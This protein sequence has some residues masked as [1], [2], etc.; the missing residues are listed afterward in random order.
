M[1]RKNDIL[2]KT[3]LEEVFGDLLRFVFKDA[4]QI[5]DMDRGFEFLDKELAEIYPEPEKDSH[6]RFVDKLVKVFRKDGREEWLLVHVEV[7]GETEAKD[8]A[9]FAVRMLEY[10]TRI[11]FKHRKPVAAIAIF[12]GPDG[13]QMPD[14][15]NYEFKNTR[16]EFQYHTLCILDYDDET[17]ASS[18]NPFA[19]V[20]LAA[21]K[22]MVSGKDV[23]AKLLE[24]KLFVFRKLY[25]R[26]IFGKPNMEAILEFLNNYV[27]FE[28]SKTNRIFTEEIDKITGNTNTMDRKE[29]RK[30]GDENAIRL[31]L[32]NTE[33]PI[34][35][36]A[37]L[38][39]VSVDFVRKVKEGKR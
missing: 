7:Q 39:G 22:A 27:R 32:Q 24:G 2:W 13:K 8:R 26:G 6:T 29:G 21:K 28:N 19:L 17:L 23:D 18:D 20:M 1:R 12:T 4:D 38:V 33:F 14:R 25:E 11:F 10:F 36:I 3:V 5:F 34:G 31:F 35:K 37:N 30:E 16:L 9:G 15:F